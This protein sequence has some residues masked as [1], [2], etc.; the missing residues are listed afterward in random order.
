MPEIREIREIREITPTQ[1]NQP[2]KLRVCA[3]ARVSSDSDDQLNSFY[4]Q[5]KYYTDFIGKKPEWEFVD[6]YADEGLT[7]TRADKRD[8]FQRLLKDCRKGK[9]DRIITKS[10]SR[11]S[12]NYRDCIKT[13][14]ELQDIGVEVEFEKENINTGKISSEMFLT[15]L[16]SMAQ[17]ES[18]SIS[19]NMRLGYQMRMKNGKFITCSAP[20]GYKLSGRELIVNEDE[21]KIVRRIFQSYLSGK[22]FYEIAAD[23]SS[24]KIPKRDGTTNWRYNMISYIL[25]NEKY[26]GDALLQKSCTTDTLPFHRKRNFG[27]KTKYYFQN[28]HEAIIDRSVFEK[29]KNLIAIKR[30]TYCPTADPQQYPLSRMIQCGECGSTY[31]RKVTRGITYWTCYRH[32]QSKNLCSMRQI[33]ETE[34][35]EAFVRLYNKLKHNYR[36]IL[37]P[38][39]EQ[40]EVLRDREER[41]NSR[42]G[43][44]NKN[45]AKFN[46]QIHVLNSLKSKGYMESAV[47][48]EQ[49]TKITQEID[50]LKEAKRNMLDHDEDDHAISDLKDL[51]SIVSTS[52]GML[53]KF[54]EILFGSIIEKVTTESGDKIRF[55]LLGGLE[56][57]E[58]VKRGAAAL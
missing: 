57:A 16:S 22:G 54:D 8:D 45:I 48:S 14:R 49:I 37:I 31:K 4:A 3:Y 24:S 51:I 20:Y 23:L 58:P 7:G 12:R 40:L 18:L 56:L 35:Y 19:G 34:I 32:E 26:M 33:P 44:L 52:S 11:F 21:A 27:Q 41:S 53:T 38:V 17:E 9:I 46:Q 6:I 15:I 47:F 42:I 55:R 30:D 36:S 5:V 28:S 1:S 10:V 43:D 13:I 2:A 25:Q 29:T 50:K 39:V